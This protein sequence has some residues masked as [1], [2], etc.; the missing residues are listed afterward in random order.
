MFALRHRIHANTELGFEKLETSD[1]VAKQLAAW[2]YEVHCGL[3]GTGMVAT[4]R[5]GNLMRISEER[6]RCFRHRDH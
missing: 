4:M 5:I 3:A 6:D 1:L 2:G